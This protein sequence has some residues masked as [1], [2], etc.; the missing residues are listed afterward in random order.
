MPDQ[1]TFAMTMSN[2]YKYEI[3]YHSDSL[4]IIWQLWSVL[5]FRSLVRVAN[6]SVIML[7]DIN[8]EHILQGRTNSIWD[9]VQQ[10][11]PSGV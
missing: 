2:F 6:N 4:I 8:K 11:H 9:G 1:H 3:V 7:I 10:N 5:R